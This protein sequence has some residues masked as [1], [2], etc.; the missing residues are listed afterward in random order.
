MA[1]NASPNRSGHDPRTETCREN[2][3]RLA[4]YHRRSW[5][6]TAMYRYKQLI[7]ST[8]RARRFYSQRVE[9]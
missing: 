2:W 4:G 7:G 1:R 9:T 6:E 3:K 8:L 5:A